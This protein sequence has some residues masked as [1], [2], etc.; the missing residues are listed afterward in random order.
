M[1][2]HPQVKR[3]GDHK[4]SRCSRPEEE[5]P[6]TGGSL[7]VVP[8]IDVPFALAPLSPGHLLHAVNFG[9]AQLGVESKVHLPSFDGQVAVAP[10]PEL[11]QVLVVEDIERVVPGSTETTVSSPALAQCPTHWPRHT[12]PPPHVA[13][14]HAAFASERFSH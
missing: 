13:P 7:S 1:S 6:L 10:V 5:G 8:R 11:L 12:D 9:D 4:R 2:P 3:G 14:E